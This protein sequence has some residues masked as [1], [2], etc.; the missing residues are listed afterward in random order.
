MPSAPPDSLGGAPGAGIQL[1]GPSTIRDSTV[2]GN[3]GTVTGTPTRAYVAGAALDNEDGFAVT[4]A[5]STI[6]D[7]AATATTSGGTAIVWGAAVHN[8]GDLTLRNTVVR[9]NTGIAS[10][11]DGMAQGGGVWNDSADL[12]FGPPG[13]PAHLSLYDSTITRNRLSASSS[14]FSE[15]L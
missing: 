6:T 14:N 7:N 8:N 15:G 12:L 3:R 11:L 10:G 9:G 2:T 13:P 4:V 5:D 1:G